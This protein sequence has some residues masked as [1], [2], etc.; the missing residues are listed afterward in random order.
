MVPTGGGPPSLPDTDSAIRV[1]ITQRERAE[2]RWGLILVI[3]MRLLAGLWVLQ[4]M[5]QWAQILLPHD[6]IFD[7][8]SR[9]QVT[10]I[11]FFAVIDFLA[12]VGLWLATPWGGVLWL[13][14]VVSQI[15]VALTVPGVFT[16]VWVALDVVLIGLYFVLTFQAGRASADR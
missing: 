16:P 9:G 6:L 14:A 7:H 3:F 1:G 13:V 4:G 5:S 8:L 11:M 15:F 12:A 10:A 2:T